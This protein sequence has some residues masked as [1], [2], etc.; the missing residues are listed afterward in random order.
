MKMRKKVAA[1]A[2]MEA[3]IG[4][5]WRVVVWSWCGGEEGRVWRVHCACLYVCGRCACLCRWLCRVL[6]FVIVY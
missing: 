3:V 4:K 1:S 6:A 5:V 2:V